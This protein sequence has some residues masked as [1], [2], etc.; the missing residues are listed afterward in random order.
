VKSKQKGETILVIYSAKTDKVPWSDKEWSFTNNYYRALNYNS[1]LFD[2]SGYGYFK[3]MN[4]I[5]YTY[6][7]LTTFNTDIDLRDMKLAIKKLRE[8]LDKHPEIKN[9]KDYKCRNYYDKMC[10]WCNLY[11]QYPTEQVS[12]RICDEVQTTLEHL[13]KQGIVKISGCNLKKNFY[14]E[15]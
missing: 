14:T 5:Y 2:G 3:I 11:M 4:E 15:D 8:N 9:C 12:K 6:N 7:M 10:G 1:D 13:C